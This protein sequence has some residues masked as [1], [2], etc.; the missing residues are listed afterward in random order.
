M[1]HPEHTDHE[2]PSGQRVTPTAATSSDLLSSGHHSRNKPVCVWVGLGARQANAQMAQMGKCQRS[3]CQ[4]EHELRKALRLRLRL[5]P[6]FLCPLFNRSQQRPHMCKAELRDPALLTIRKPVKNCKGECGGRGPGPALS[7]EL[8]PLF[9]HHPGDPGPSTPARDTRDS[10]D[11][12]LESSMSRH[13][14]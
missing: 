8:E 2:G 7:A 1:Y 12:R 5:H 3:I 10:L 9:A 13:I 14:V 6:A 11:S 4:K